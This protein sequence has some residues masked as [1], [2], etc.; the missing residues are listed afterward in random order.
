MNGATLLIVGI[1]F[2]L[3]AYRFYG[4][5]LARLFEIDSGRETPAHTR[6]DGIDYVPA[7]FPVLF[8]HHF[9]SIAGAGPI[10]GPVLAVYL[11]AV[12]IRDAR[13]ILP[14][15]LTGDL[16]GFAAAV[17]ACHVFFA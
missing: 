13:H 6:T 2:F 9:A 11:G 12:G 8:G 10:V 14:A 5:Y 4:R 16:A 7:K 3:F 15:C 17:L 1:I